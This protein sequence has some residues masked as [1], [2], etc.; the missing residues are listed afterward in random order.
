MPLVGWL[1]M[2]SLEALRG[3]LI[4]TSRNPTTHAAPRPLLPVFWPPLQHP[5]A[6]PRLP[7][8]ISAYQRGVS[9]HQH[10]MIQ[11]QRRVL[12]HQAQDDPTPAQGV[13][14]PAQHATFNFQGSSSS[15]GPPALLCSAAAPATQHSTLSTPSQVRRRPRHSAS[16]G[17]IRITCACAHRVRHASWCAEVQ[18]QRK[19]QEREAATHSFSQTTQRG[20]A[21][22]PHV[23][24]CSTASQPKIHATGGRS[25]H[26]LRPY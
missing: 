25:R 16:I 24:P 9:P 12:A 19:Q 20:R 5:Q 15:S 3:R 18:R 23:Q 8:K 22:A 7:A 10:S 13:T 14:T 4:C 11:H 6:R 17:N 1:L 26:Y 2:R 21:R